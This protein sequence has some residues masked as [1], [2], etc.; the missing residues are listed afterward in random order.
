MLAISWQK[1]FGTHLF[2][3]FE[4][5]L[6]LTASPSLLHRED[7]SRKRNSVRFQPPLLHLMEQ[8]HR[9][10]PLAAPLTFFHLNAVSTSARIHVLLLHLIKKRKS[11][12]PLSTI[13][14]HPEHSAQCVV[15]ECATLHPL[16]LHLVEQT[17]CRPPMTVTLCLLHRTE[18]RVE[19]DGV[20]LYTPLLHLFKKP[21][22]HLPLA[23]AFRFLHHADQRIVS[24][25]I[26]CKPFFLHLFE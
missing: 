2:Y 25:C 19:R 11:S 7:Q 8:P 1:A 21:K 12:L 20:R 14:H 3:Q 24:C 17:K 23:A 22:R 15:S 13:L 16:S 4:R 10:P 26:G 9:D 5:T 6:P 18:Q